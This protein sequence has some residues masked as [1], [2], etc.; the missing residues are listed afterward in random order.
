MEKILAAV[1]GGPDKNYV[2]LGAA[3]I[4]K[5]WLISS[6]VRKILGISHGTL[7]NVHDATSKHTTVSK[8]NY[9]GCTVFVFNA[10]NKIDAIIKGPTALGSLSRFFSLT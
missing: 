7:Q 9:F 8:T 1:I 4:N 5:E 10:S 6:E 3:T 2:G